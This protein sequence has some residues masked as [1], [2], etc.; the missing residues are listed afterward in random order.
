MQEC[1][2]LLD[3]V[4]LEMEMAI[5]KLK[6][7][8]AKKRLEEQREKKKAARNRDRIA[9]EE[10]FKAAI[11]HNMTVVP[12]RND[13]GAICYALKSGKLTTEELSKD[14]MPFWKE[15]RAKK[16]SAGSRGF[17]TRNEKYRLREPLKIL[18]QEVAK[19]R[20]GTDWESIFKLM[21]KHICEMEGMS[22]QLKLIED[23]SKPDKH[24]LVSR[25]F[26]FKIVQ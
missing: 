3:D 9:L 11:S 25:G 18:V 21:I 2:D 1:D 23:D 10:Y 22:N 8:E 26:K 12:F 14:L 5:T 16:P 19:Q 24:I 6:K 17:N 13:R 20:F 7:K 15:G 4:D